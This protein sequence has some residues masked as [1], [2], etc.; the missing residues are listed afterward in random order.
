M[1]PVNRDEKRLENSD[2]N[3]KTAV[4]EML[5]EVI[6]DF[7]EPNEKLEILSKEK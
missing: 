6:T 7:L 4:T 1:R 3:F 2:K 5:Q